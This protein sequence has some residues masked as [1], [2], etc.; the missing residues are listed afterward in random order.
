MVPTTQKWDKMVDDL[1][2]TTKLKVPHNG[3]MCKDKWNGFNFEYKKVA[4]YHARTCDC[5][6]HFGI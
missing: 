4:H 3:E 1:Q 6:F 5:A 2:K